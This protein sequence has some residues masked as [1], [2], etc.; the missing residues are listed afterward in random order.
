MSFRIFKSLLNALYVLSLC[1]KMNYGQARHIYYLQIPK[2]EIRPPVPPPRTIDPPA[3]FE[4][5]RV[6]TARF[7][8]MT[9]DNFRLISVLGRGHF[10]KVKYN[11]FV[12]KINVLNYNFIYSGD[13][14]TVQKH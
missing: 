13:P 4:T 5:R 10:G 9:F 6:T 1:V 3:M 2:V 8:G 12:K 14:G 7:T 11:Y